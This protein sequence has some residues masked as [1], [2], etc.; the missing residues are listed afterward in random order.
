MLEYL[1]FNEYFE[2]RF[3]ESF[4]FD[5]WT[6]WQVIIRKKVYKILLEVELFNIVKG[7]RKRGR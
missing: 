6:N 5:W 4:K 7:N 3:D 1:R 2:L